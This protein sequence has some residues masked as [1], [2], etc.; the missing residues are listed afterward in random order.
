MINCRPTFAT[1]NAK[2]VNLRCD[3]RA[4]P[5][6]SAMFWIVDVNGTTVSHGEVINEYWTLVTVSFIR[7]L[8]EPPLIRVCH[9]YI[10]VETLR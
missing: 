9:L 4:K 3:V 7:F 10:T 8:R 1:L 6:L 5:Q 2:S